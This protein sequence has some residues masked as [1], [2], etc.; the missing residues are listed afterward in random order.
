MSI[1]LNKVLVKLN[2]GITT[3]VEFL[4]KKGFAV[5][6]DM[7]AKIS[8]EEYELLSKEFD[9]DFNLKAEAEKLSQERHHKEQKESVAVEGYEKPKQPAEIKTEVP[10]EIKPCYRKTGFG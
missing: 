9:K 4:Q 6:K 8:D 2:V 3:A 5:E 1:R 10:K 7:N